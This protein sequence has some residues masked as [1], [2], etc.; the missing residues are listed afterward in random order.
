MF[1]S[2]LTLLTM[3]TENKGNSST[4]FDQKL[5]NQPSSTSE[6]SGVMSRGGAVKDF[7]TDW[8]KSHSQ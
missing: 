5:K 1:S 2:Q 3:K 4:G 8:D 6:A 7:I